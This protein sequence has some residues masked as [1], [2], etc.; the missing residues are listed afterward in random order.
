MRQLKTSPLQT[1]HLSLSLSISLA[2]TCSRLAHRRWWCHALSTCCEIGFG[3]HSL[4]LMS[5]YK[6]RSWV[7]NTFSL[8][9]VWSA[10]TN[11]KPKETKQK[12][13]LLSDETRKSNNKKKSQLKC[14]QV[15]FFQNGS[16][17]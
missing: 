3:N 11:S 2:L 1:K 15:N 14:E 9:F 17:R 16:S 10:T 7:K 8:Y 13:K 6:E 12:T 4:Q 5:V